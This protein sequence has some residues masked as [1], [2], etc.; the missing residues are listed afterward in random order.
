[1]PPP[2]W[3]GT[4]RCRC[5]PTFADARVPKIATATRRCM[6]HMT[7][8]WRR[9]LPDCI[10]RRNCSSACAQEA[11]PSRRSICTSAPAPSSRS[12]GT[13]VVR[14]L[15]SCAAADGSIRPGA[16]ETRAFIYPPYTFR[17]V[18]RLLTNFHLPRSTLLMLVCAFGGY[19][20]VMGAYRE[21][22][23]EGYRFYSYG[24]AMAVT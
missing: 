13:T 17:A 6:R 11:R 22:I 9:P 15:E 16:G 8:A 19:E 5:R 20:H 4:A 1:M 23:A 14:T 7:A 24:D 12:M 21:A 10:S 18:D 3:P 2:R